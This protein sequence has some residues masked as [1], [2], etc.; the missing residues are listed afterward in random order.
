MK[1]Q[2]YSKDAFKLSRQ[3]LPYVK[4]KLFCFRHFRFQPRVCRYFHKE[5][6]EFNLMAASSHDGTNSTLISVYWTQPLPYWAQWEH[7]WWCFHGRG[8]PS[9][10]CPPPPTSPR[11]A[12]DCACSSLARLFCSS[13]WTCTHRGEWRCPLLEVWA[14]LNEAG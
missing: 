5:K 6:L 2:C 7:M 1:Q 4:V 10:S 14:Y 8:C 9:S 3:M 13:G 12:S 11:W